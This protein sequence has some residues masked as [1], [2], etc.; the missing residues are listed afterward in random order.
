LESICIF[1]LVIPFLHLNP[2]HPLTYQPATLIAATFPHEVLPWEGPILTSLIDEFS[3]EDGRGHG[4]KLEC[5]VMLP[6]LFFPIFPWAGGLSFKELS[7][8]FRHMSGFV[9]IDRDRDTGTVFPDPVDG[10]CRIKYTPSAW[11]RQR[12]IEGLLGMCR[13]LYVQGATEILT[14]TS[15][16][17]PFIRPAPSS[18]EDT[19]DAGINDPTFTSWLDLLRAKGL[20][21]PDASFASAHQ[22]GT[23][24]MGSSPKTSVVDQ[25][26]KAWEAEG[27][28]V[29]DASVFPSASGVNPMITNM[30]IAEWVSG[31]ISR[32]LK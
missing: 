14:A 30:G 11:D 13:I 17:P 7:A 19:M 24:R 31:G 4:T 23:C 16:V 5:T 2:P 15:G 25:N 27:L 21:L 12:M 20:P 1:T 8:K 29:V 26:A 28:Y 3:N 32:G 10:R 9:V 22:M 6:S 18:T